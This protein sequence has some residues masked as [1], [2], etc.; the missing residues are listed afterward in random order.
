M[1]N[2]D[3]I[4]GVVVCLLISLLGGCGKHQSDAPEVV[5]T[6]AHATVLGY[7]NS[8]DYRITIRS[9]SQEP[10]YTVSEQNGN[11]LARDLALLELSMRFPDLQQV[12]ETGSA[13]FDARLAPS[14]V[15]IQH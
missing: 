11:V 13:D 3:Q 2:T 9:G 15:E 6:E 1:V 14:Q 7:L 4:Y 12:V 10:L 8:K 5:E